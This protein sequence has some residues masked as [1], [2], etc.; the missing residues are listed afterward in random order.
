MLAPNS[1]AWAIQL[2]QKHPGTHERMLK[3]QFVNTAH[4]RQVGALAGRG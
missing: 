3:M 4:E 2:I 1:D